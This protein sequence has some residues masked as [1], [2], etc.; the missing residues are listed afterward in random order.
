MHA[1]AGRVT[2]P[3]CCSAEAVY[4]AA[5][6]A[7]RPLDLPI[8][9]DDIEVAMALVDQ[10]D[11]KGIAFVGAAIVIS[12]IVPGDGHHAI[13][14]VQLVVDG[15]AALRPGI[16]VGPECRDDRMV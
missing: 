9:I 16:D 14:G 11:L 10:H 15:A 12:D 13:G 3:R 6:G 7:C 8:A 2:G 4:A 1:I 5:G